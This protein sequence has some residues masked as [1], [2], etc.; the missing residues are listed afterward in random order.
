M[1]Q[2]LKS[3]PFFAELPQADLEAIA[4]K[5]TMEYFPAGHVLFNEGDPGEKMYIIKTGSV[6]VIRGSA[7]VATLK[8]GEF[9]GEMALVSELPRTATIK[10]ASDVELL[11][12]QKEDFRHLLESSPSI[13]SK[14]SYEVVHRVNQND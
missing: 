14:V 11:V 5:V 1:I 12:L 3:V 6:E 8:D 9:F 2:I 7:N 13:A 4:S 10:A